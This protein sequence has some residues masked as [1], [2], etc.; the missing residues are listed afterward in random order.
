MSQT[1]VVFLA[2]NALRF[3]MV[4][5]YVSIGATAVVRR[6]QLGAA[7]VPA[8]LGSSSLGLATILSFAT[9]YWQITAA[10]AG[11]EALLH[12]ASMVGLSN[13]VAQSLTVIGAASLGFAIFS[14]RPVTRGDAD[15]S[16]Q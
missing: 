2:G 7:T 11:R 5:V 9:Y 4:L 13:Y 8:V 16:A 10:R 15:Q 3:V 6:A 14:G 1:M 12:I